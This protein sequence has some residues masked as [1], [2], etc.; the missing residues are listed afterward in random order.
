[1]VGQRILIAGHLQAAVMTGAFTAQN[2]IEMSR[3]QK[4]IGWKLAFLEDSLLSGFLAVQSNRG[5]RE[6]LKAQALAE[7]KDQGQE[8]VA[9]RAAWGIANIANCEPSG[10]SWRHSCRSKWRPAT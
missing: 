2:L 4:R 6:S 1:M 5:K 10:S 9:S 7:A 3:F 8:A